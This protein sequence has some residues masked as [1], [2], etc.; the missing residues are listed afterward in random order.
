MAPPQRIIAPSV[1]QK[2]MQRTAAI[3]CFDTINAGPV[4]SVNQLKKKM[5][6]LYHGDAAVEDNLGYADLMLMG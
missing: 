2:E 6:L 1:W 4:L 3:A 5:A